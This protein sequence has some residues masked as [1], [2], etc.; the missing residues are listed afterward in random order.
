MSQEYP[1][2][3]PRVLDLRGN[4]AGIPVSEH[5]SIAWPCH[6]WRVTLPVKRQGTLNLFEETALRLI[7][8]R[9]YDALGLAE[10]LCLPAD[11]V[12][13]ILLRLQ[14]RAL[15]AASNELTI[16]GRNYLKLS[17]EEPTEYEGRFLFREL[18][19]GELL[20]VL[21]TGELCCETLVGWR[22]N[23]LRIEK[24]TAGK[25]RTFP[26]RIIPR[27]PAHAA[28][29]PPMVTDVIEVQ[30]QH[31]RLN[32]QYS[33]LRGAAPAEIRAQAGQVNI[34]SEPESYLLMC[35]LLVPEGSTEFLISDPFGYG[36][37][38]ILDRAYRE[39]IQRDPGEEEYL[40]RLKDNAIGRQA[41]KAPEGEIRPVH[42]DSNPEYPEFGRLFNSI[43]YRM[44]RLDQKVGSREQEAAVALDRQRLVQ[45]LYSAIEW[46]LRY[47]LEKTYDE[48][49]LALLCVGTGE[50]NAGILKQMANAV[51]LHT[52]RS[53]RFLNIT[54][55]RVRSFNY[56]N[57]D[58]QCLVAV[59]IASAHASAL[60][61]LRSV[62]AA[63]P[64]WLSF[65]VE[66]KQDRD[67]VA[68]GQSSRLPTDRLKAHHARTMATI[69]LLLPDAALDNAPPT[70][71][72][73]NVPARAEF[74]ARMA[75]RITIERRLGV[76]TFKLLGNHIDN[77][78]VG[79]EKLA[80]E[81]PAAGEIE[82]GNLVGDLCAAL[83]AAIQQAVS[84]FN[85]MRPDASGDLLSRAAEQ[86]KLAGFNLDNRS[87]PR[88]LR[89]VRT[90]GVTQALGGLGPSLGAT[91]LA[92]LLLA[93]IPWLERIAKAQGDY[94]AVIARAITLRGHGNRSIYL[95]ADELRLFKEE[96]YQTIKTTA[97]T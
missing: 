71:A 27:I 90:T 58:M 77:L 26:L 12:E 89:T 91:A 31:R 55:G 54:P 56:G 87:L 38:D 86:A 53:A 30:H 82:A 4:G 59:G 62:A 85:S 74:E 22:G 80:S 75:A 69:K 32:R 45:D 37:S 61:P 14:D 24:G 5:K 94:L 6:A 7:A 46:A 28:P 19:G 17:E 93:P 13:F 67:P 44:E 8:L 50:T 76:Q 25:A 2:G 49:Q 39:L 51:G 23:I 18:V 57:A 60:H 41:A 40:L 95:P 20:P 29:N 43:K 73:S 81:L 88:S 35:E 96:I 36:C 72:A 84:S 34:V 97:G 33:L 52:D 68:H 48:A 47:C 65:V 83:Q 1:A 92:L 9:R 16:E 10:T 66:I 15:L 63:M 79:V 42:S 11:L 64:G 70:G 78:L 21:W 3:R